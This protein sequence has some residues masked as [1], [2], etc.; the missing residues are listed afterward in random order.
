M[1]LN[2]YLSKHL[3]HQLL[4]TSRIQTRQFFALSR[5]LSK[6]AS[7]VQESFANGASSVYMDQMYDQWKQDPESVNVSWRSYF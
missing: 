3:K 1:I 5:P 6:E 7:T 4:S 2:R